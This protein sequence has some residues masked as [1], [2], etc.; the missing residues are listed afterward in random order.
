MNSLYNQ[1]RRGQSQDLQATPPQTNQKLPSSNSLKALM[2]SS[3][4]Q[5]FI[6]NMIKNNPQ[7]QNLMQVFNSSGLTPKQF[8]YNYARQKGID[9]EQFLQNLK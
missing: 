9:P 6:Q 7:A 2:N 1:L 8:F 4:P 3:D 5:S